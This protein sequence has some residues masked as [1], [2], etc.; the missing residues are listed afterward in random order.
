MLFYKLNKKLIIVEHTNNAEPLRVVLNCNKIMSLRRISHWTFK[1]L[2]AD[3]YSRQHVH[4]VHH[5]TQASATISHTALKPILTT[6]EYRASQP[7]LTKTLFPKYIRQAAHS[8]CTKY[9]LIG[10]LLN[11]YCLSPRHSSS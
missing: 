4:C 10:Y 5:T 6:A 7:L 11:T 9:S 1:L 8:R 3:A 2:P